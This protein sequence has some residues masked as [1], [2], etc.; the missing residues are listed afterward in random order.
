M[1]T[2]VSSGVRRSLVLVCTLI[3]C[4]GLIMV[5]R[6]GADAPATSDTAVIETYTR[7][8]S[9][10]Q[11]WLGAYSRFQWHHPGPLPFYL[12]APFYALSGGMTTGLHAGAAALSLGFACLTIAVLLRR[13]PAL[14]VTG[15]AALAVLAWRSAEALGSPWNPH[16]TLLPMVALMVVTA[17]VIAGSPRSLPL[18]ALCASLAAQAHVALVPTALALGVVACVRALMG[19][20][21]SDARRSPW[22]RSLLAMSVV[23]LVVWMMPLVEQLTGTP[24]GNVTE[25]WQFFAVQ[26]RPGQPIGVAV[27]A[28]SDMFVGVLRPD[29]YVAHGWPWVESPVLWAEW[30]TL[31]L[32]AV[33]AARAAR[34]AR[35]GDT[36]T[37]ALGAVVLLASSS[38]LWSATR[39]EDRIF[40]HD[41]F[42]MAAPGVLALTLLSD[43][44]LTTACRGWHAGRSICA[45]ACL[46]GLAAVAW[47]V[48]RHLEAQVEVSHRPPESARAAR[49][50]ADDLERFLTSESVARPLVLIDQDAWEYVAG[51]VLDLQKRGMPVSFEEDWVVMFTPRFRKTGQ[52]DVL[53]TVAAAKEHERLT[54]RGVRLIS[55]HAPVFVHVEPIT[56]R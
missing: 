46:F 25:L 27:S 2:T 40:D 18:V 43:W 22:L 50:M 45:T 36:F 33:T 5:A 31:A 19:L 24:R 3:V 48:V 26:S 28:W 11:L 4:A 7:L 47:P 34:G 23:L 39:V 6:R 42:W 9:H 51:A 10:A 54:A 55:A 14:A 41:V 1:L 15:S 44:L 38:A 20:R 29:F 8:A 53:I 21:E 16:M 49:A 13:R 32:L 37:A 12:L 52:E 30:G 17:D 35:F 56:R